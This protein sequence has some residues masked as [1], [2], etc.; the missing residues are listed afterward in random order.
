MERPGVT[1]GNHSLK[2]LP[3][4]EE[5]QQ[6]LHRTFFIPTN[7]RA[8][9]VEAK[10]GIGG[11]SGGISLRVRKHDKSGIQVHFFSSK[12]DVNCDKSDIQESTAIYG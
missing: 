4:K 9:R 3:R 1:H 7:T 8:C 6:C 11:R 10:S 12:S 5:R 2:E